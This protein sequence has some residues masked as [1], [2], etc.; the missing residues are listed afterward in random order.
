MPQGLLRS[1]PFLTH[2]VFNTHHSE[3]ELLRYMRS[4]ADKD[5]AMDRTKL[6]PG[7][8]DHLGGGIE[9]HRAAAQRD[10]GAIHPLAPAEQSAGYAQ[11][12]DELEA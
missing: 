8:R 11:L 1:T 2:P 3:H 6:G 7:H 4:L 9:L 10:H 12:I 5:L